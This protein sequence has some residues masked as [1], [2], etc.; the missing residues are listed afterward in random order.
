MSLLAI[1]VR[2]FNVIQFNS[3][4]H[5]LNANKSY[6]SDTEYVFNIFPHDLFQVSGI[7]RYLTKNKHI[8][9]EKINKQRI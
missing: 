3:T 5:E 2:S 8:K 6:K 4:L 7:F 1:Q 9:M